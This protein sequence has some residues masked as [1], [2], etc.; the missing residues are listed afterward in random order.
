MAMLTRIKKKQWEGLK[1]FVESLEVTPGHQRQQ[2]LLNGILEDPL[3]MRWVT[4]NLR[5]FEDFLSLPNDQ[6]EALLRTGEALLTVV[7]KAMP[8][9]KAAAPAALAEKFGRFFPKLQEELSFL[10]SLRAEEREAAQ[11]FV[12]KTVRRLQREEHIRGF[13]WSLP[14]Q[15][16]FSAEASVRDGVDTVAFEDGTVAAQ[17]ERLKGQRIGKWRHYYDHGRLL[18]EGNYLQGLKTGVWVFFYG[19]GEKRAQGS[20]LDDQRHGDWVDWNR[21]GTKRTSR[22]VEGKKIED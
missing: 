4:K 8:A 11:F 19:S 3:Y 14:P 21:D 17:G 5:T 9:E 2:I 18:A 10:P 22:W 12:L 6:L 20:Y 13:D 15:Q 16:L 1:D 7:A